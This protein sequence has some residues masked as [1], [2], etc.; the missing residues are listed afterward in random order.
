MMPIPRLASACL[1][2]ALLVGTVALADPADDGLEAI[3]RSIGERRQLYRIGL[4]SS[5][6]L[7]LSSSGR[8]RIVDPVTGKPVWKDVYRGEVAVVAE[9]GPTE[10]IPAVYRIQVGA[11][12][13]RKAAD[14]ERARLEKRYG[15][16]AVVRHIPDRGSWRVRLGESRDREGLGDLMDRLRQD[17]LEGLWIV[18]EPSRASANVT[19]RL[20][21]GSY[22]SYASGLSR[23]AVVPVGKSR[24]EV[25]GRS[26]RGLIELRVTSFGTARAV[27]WVELESYLLGV[28]PAELGPEVWPQLEA[29]KAQSVAARTYAWKHRGQ[30]EDEGFDLCGTPRCQVYSGASAEHPMSDRAVAET[31]GQILTWKGDPISALYTATCGGHTE[32]AAE[33]FPEEKAPYL[34][35]VPCRAEGDAIATLRIGLKGAQIDPVTTEQGEQVTRDWALLTAAGVLPAGAGPGDLARTPSP[36]TLRRWTL[37]L[38]SLAGRPLPEGRP[39]PLDDL[40]SAAAAIVEDLGWDERARVLLDEA[41]VPALV[42]DPEAQRLPP[43]SRRALAYLALSGGLRPFPDGSHRISEPPSGARLLPVLARIGEAYRAFGLTSGVVAG[44]SMERLR[45]AKGKG[46]IRL[47]LADAPRLFGLSGGKTV[48]A[49]G[50]ELWPGDRVR[51]RTDRTGKIDFLELVPPVKGTSD[52]RS[53]AVYSWEVRKTRREL[54]RAV[55]RR[56]NIGRLQDLRVV[57]RGRSGRAVELKVIGSDGE[58]TVRGFD[59]RRLLGLRESLTV[60]E[61]Q[62]DSQGEIRAVVFAGKGWGHGVGLCQ[63]GAYGMALRGSD[64]REILAHYYRGA[65]L[66]TIGGTSPGGPE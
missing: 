27:N 15:G 3:A 50:L 19:L 57:R 48:P 65:D 30:F 56:V 23:L 5:H 6:K 20:V 54:E 43:E 51:Y 53:A 63:V 18:E 8:F 34:V 55:N 13:T 22:D 66:K 42:R 35:G 60:I 52:D 11:F 41:D 61:L 38:S 46:E 25:E 37:A 49:P 9:G 16:S 26:Y 45:L 62:R 47:R 64:Y 36:E 59:V 40:G 1:L 7:L 17:G 14:R 28:V 10:G 24:L 29:L 4:D 58:T 44:G 31:R 39:G 21:D 33:I 32:D 2:G 12:S